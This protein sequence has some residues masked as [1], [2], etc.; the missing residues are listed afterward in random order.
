MYNAITN[1]RA[2][3]VEL[4]DFTKKGS[5]PGQVKTNVKELEEI[6]GDRVKQYLG[7]TYKIFNEKSILPFANYEPTD[8]AI[9]RAVR[10]F[11]RYSR[12]TQ[13]NN[14]TVK[15]ISEQEAR[16]M[17]KSVLDSVPKTKPKIYNYLHLNMLTLLQE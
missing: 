14:K 16:A 7:N 11:Q 5:S 2:A 13:R 17:V 12:F 8:E 6:M 10:L 9:N 1:S 3:F 15:E 4:L